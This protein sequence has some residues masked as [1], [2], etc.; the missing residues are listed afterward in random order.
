MK[1]YANQKPFSF[2]NEIIIKDENN[3]DV[4]DISSEIRAMGTK[5][6]ITNMTG[7]KIIYIEEELLNLISTHSIYINNQPSITIK[8]IIKPFVACNYTLSNLYI[9]NGNFRGTDFTIYDDKN[10]QIGNIKRTTQILT[11]GNSE[12]FEI[13]IIDNNQKEIILAILATITDD[14]RRDK[15]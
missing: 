9:V 2:S 5:T 3:I 10:N 11:I 12:S 8:R 13:E 15:K 14:I 4:Y 1:L 7:N 6:T